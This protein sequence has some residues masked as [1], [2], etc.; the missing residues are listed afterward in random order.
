MCYA[1]E[2]ILAEKL[3]S[4]LQRGKARDYYDVWRL[5]GEKAGA[6]DPVTTRRVLITKCAH[7]GLPE[8][9]PA[10]FLH[11]AI[12]QEAANYWAQDLADQ[13]PSGKLPPWTQVIEELARSLEQFLT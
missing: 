4:I 11:P 12:L 1:L 3:R 13:I 6:F 10:D 2:E 8:P 9:I 7:K 5:L